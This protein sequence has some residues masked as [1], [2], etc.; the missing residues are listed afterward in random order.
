MR[1]RTAL[2]IEI[3]DHSGLTLPERLDKIILAELR[4]NW[5]RLSRAAL[6]KAFAE[7]KILLGGATASPSTMIER[8]PI[9]IDIT[10]WSPEMA[11][12]PKA[13]PSKHGSFL[14]I[15]F[16]DDELLVLNKRSGV[17]SVPHSSDETETAVGAA[18][19]HLTATNPEFLEIGRGGLE[20]GILHRLDTGTSG[21]LVFAKN[22]AEFTRLRA[23]WQNGAVIK[24]YRALVRES[25]PA[26]GLERIELSSLTKP[27]TI[28]LPLAHDSKSSKRMVAITPTL[29]E[30]NPKIG[31][32]ALTAQ[33]T[34]LSASKIQ[35]SFF[36][37]HV[38]IATG[39]MHQIRCHLS[40]YGWPIMGDPV[41]N[42]TPSRRL[43]LHAWKLT[44]PRQDGSSL[45]LEAP[46]PEG[47]A[48]RSG[49]PF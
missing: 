29:E 26:S 13:S 28:S 39:V 7:D 48:K 3:S 33:T 16:E 49:P 9:V 24:E 14:D 27:L 40:S 25:K 34:I 46:L 37:L 12:S 42:G 45:K 38:S 10:D 44:I 11:E 6:K 8:L 21:L 17:P 32:E 47:W 36:D 31:D 35:D 20:P 15:V 5:P 41:Y 2:T 1:S 30:R 19:A 22:D 4:K 18:L 23:A 43:W